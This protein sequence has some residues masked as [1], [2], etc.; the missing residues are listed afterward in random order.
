MSRGNRS[1]VSRRRFAPARSSR[2][3][4]SFQSMKRQ[5]A[6]RCCGLSAFC[7][8]VCASE[9][10][11]C[12]NSDVL[13]SRLTRSKLHS[14]SKKNSEVFG[15]LL[16]DRVVE[17]S[18][19]RSMQLSVSREVPLDVAQFDVRSGVAHDAYCSAQSS[20]SQGGRHQD[21]RVCPRSIASIM[22]K[23]ASCVQCV[24]E[25]SVRR[26]NCSRVCRKKKSCESRDG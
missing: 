26:K 2:C 5:S 6:V 15:H 13:E 4:I 10:S 7:T 9:S 8:A 23:R 12:R 14:T 3:S 19:E 18:R 21:V 1:P 22:S 24:G 17:G 16:T 11:S 20:S 25:C